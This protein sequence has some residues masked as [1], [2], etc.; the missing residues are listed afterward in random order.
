MG[1]I[2]GLVV[3]ALFAGGY[4]Y[5]QQART[6]DDCILEHMSGTTNSDA[7]NF[8]YESCQEKFPERPKAQRTL[9]SLSQ[10]ELSRIT[11][12]AGVKHGSRFSGSLYNGNDKVTVMEVEVAVTT[13]TGK[14]SS[15]RSYLTK[16]II[17][18]KTA[19]DF[20]F[21]VIAGEAKSD[22]EWQMVSARGF[23]E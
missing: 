20:G 23:E 21:D 16:V 4:V 18:P 6:F 13:A 3:V 22:Y 12:R 8:I 11:G 15:S 10:A 5:W 14:A 9:R 2:G 19:T 1:V 17:S 7:A